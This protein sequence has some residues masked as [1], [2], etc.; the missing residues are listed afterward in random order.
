MTRD[1]CLAV[2]TA[3]GVCQFTQ[4]ALNRHWTGISHPSVS[5][6]RHQPPITNHEPPGPARYN[7]THVKLKIEKLVYGGDGLARLPAD[8]HGP[9]KTTFVPFSVD[10]EVVEAQITEQKP[11]FA[12][13]QITSITE[14]SSD[15]IE[16][17]CPYFSGCGGCHYQHMTY[18]RQ[19]KTKS[20]I[21]IE[22]L[23]RT[24]KLDLPCELQVHPSP[25]WN[26]RN[27]TRLKVQVQP[28]FA[29]GYYRFRSH[30]LLPVEQCPIS[31]PLIN[32]VI[33][34][35]WAAGR[36]GDLPIEVREL[37]IFADHLD[38]NFSVE[39]YCDSRTAQI[40]AHKLA[41]QVARILPSAAGVVIFEAHPANNFSDPKRL[42]S[43]GATALT[44]KTKH[45]SYRVSAGAFFQAN[46]LLIDELVALATAGASGKLALDL[47]AGVG[48]FSAVLAGSFAQVIAVEASQTSCDDLRH[49]SPKEVK[50]VLATTEQYLAQV[51]G[52]NPD[53]VVVDPPRGGLGENVIRNLVRLNA[54]RI[55]YVSCDPS[56]LARDLRMLAGLG[57]TIAGAHLVD[58]FPQTYH[59]ESVFYLTR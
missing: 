18:A 57:Y 54:P 26:Y 8:E 33:A 6:A 43:V 44:Y 22:T 5:I 49:N 39:A 25:E 11:G 7:Q 30:D 52:L 59:I 46:R 27:R 4:I 34:Q 53:F 13:A 51:S 45:S 31:S 35:L 12:R 42:A 29:L 50:A 1:S 17:K 21:L 19:L 55:T 9:G 15:R 3:L 24:A 32:Q 41:E 37:E 14:S 2:I 40:S 28:E 58:L 10:G 47:Y 16:P 56:T 38:Q 48:L 23:K 36:K 20:E